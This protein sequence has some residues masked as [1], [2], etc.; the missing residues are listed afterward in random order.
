MQQA[1]IFIHCT[2]GHFVSV[3]EQHLDGRLCV[4]L[5]E[6]HNLVGDGVEQVVSVDQ[7]EH[8]LV[9]EF[10]VDPQCT[11][12]PLVVRVPGTQTQCERVLVF[13]LQVDP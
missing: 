11:V 12:V 10:Q 7:V 8:V 13:Q 6:Q 9:L 3:G 4:E 1:F 2:Y 5:H